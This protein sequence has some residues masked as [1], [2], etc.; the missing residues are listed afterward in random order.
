MSS[1]LDREAAVISAV[2]Q[3]AELDDCQSIMITVLDSSGGYF[4]GAAT[5]SSDVGEMTPKSSVAAPTIYGSLPLIGG[6][7]G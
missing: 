1:T 3:L 4:A 7:E 5:R 2:K 6:S